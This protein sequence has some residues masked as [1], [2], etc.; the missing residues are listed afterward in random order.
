MPPTGTGIRVGAERSCSRE[1]SVRAICAVRA[2]TSDAVLYDS[3]R[4]DGR[5][6]WTATTCA[7]SCNAMAALIGTSLVVD[8]STN[9]RAPSACGAKS[10]GTAQLAR[11]ARWSGPRVKTTRSPLDEVR[12]MN[13]ERK[14][15]R[16]DVSIGPNEIRD[17]IAKKFVAN[18]GQLGIGHESQAAFSKI[19]V[20]RSRMV[21][22]APRLGELTP[23]LP[24]AG[25]GREIHEVVTH[26]AR[27]LARQ[28]HRA[29]KGAGTR[30]GD[31]RKPNSRLVQHLQ[32]A[33]MGCPTC[34][35][36]SEREHRCRRATPARRKG[37]A[38]PTA[39]PPL[40]AAV[41]KDMAC[42]GRFPRG[43]SARRPRTQREDRAA[44]Q[45]PPSRRT[46]ARRR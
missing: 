2:R 14:R 17:E 29:D 28:N 27:T 3:T 23:H 18:G 24:A 38:C 37:V 44:F 22:L 1:S 34:C 7:S 11:K 10:P 12:R 40:G 13:G 9:K 30:S 26:L 21:A 33:E 19:G 31:S 15:K 46:P 5:S 45:S 41:A 32:D 8:P 39:P 4:G 42:V 20:V 35:P 25:R 6:S 36:A 43:A 16:C